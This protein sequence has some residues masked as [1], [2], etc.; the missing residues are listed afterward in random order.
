MLQIGQVPLNLPDEEEKVIP[1]VL[2]PIENAGEVDTVSKDIDNH[3]YNFVRAHIAGVEAMVYLLH[4]VLS[5]PIEV[6]KA[7]MGH[8]YKDVGTFDFKEV[9]EHMDI[10]VERVVHN[11]MKGYKDPLKGALHASKDM[12]AIV[13]AAKRVYQKTVGKYLTPYKGVP[14]MMGGI[15]DSGREIIGVTDAPKKK[16]ITRLRALGIIKFFSALYAQPTPKLNR[17]SKVARQCEKI[18]EK[19]G[20]KSNLKEGIDE[21]K[22][23]NDAIKEMLQAVITITEV[24]KQSPQQ[25][26]DYITVQA[27]AVLEEMGHFETDFPAIELFDQRKPNIDMAQLLERSRDELSRALIHC[28]DNPISDM[29]L[30]VNN[31]IVGVYSEYGQL[32]ELETECLKSLGQTEST[33]NRILEP[34][35]EYVKKLQADTRNRIVIVSQ[36]IQILDLLGIERPPEWQYDRAT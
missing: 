23:S 13:L 25:A 29:G 30:A 18:L 20:Y 34:G 32:V 14:E 31:N 27:Q 35:H 21:K 36:P 10:V 1:P 12:A 7:E 3:T 6:I 22:L 19:I 8:V 33:E 11:L 16:T 24:H 2:D 5:V 17:Y 28:G 9:V 4:R 26:S 15:C